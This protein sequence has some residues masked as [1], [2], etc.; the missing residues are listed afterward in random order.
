MMQVPRAKAMNALVLHQRGGR[1]IDK[2]TA[3]IAWVVKHRETIMSILGF[4]VMFAEDGTPTLVDKDKWDKA[5]AEKDNEPE[6]AETDETPNGETVEDFLNPE[7]G[8]P[9]DEV[10]VLVTNESVV[11]REDA[12]KGLDKLVKLNEEMGLYDIG[13]NEVEDGTLTKEEFDSMDDDELR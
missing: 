3:L 4:V 9:H 6:R 5:Q 7:L 8:E 13:A 10:P 12:E 2:L 11:K 1:F